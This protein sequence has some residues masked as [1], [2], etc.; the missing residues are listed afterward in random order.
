MCDEEGR[1]G[2]GWDGKGREEYWVDTFTS[3][4]FVR[5]SPIHMKTFS[6]TTTLMCTFINAVPYYYSLL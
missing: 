3:A 2:E 5:P 6:D 4:V 1:G